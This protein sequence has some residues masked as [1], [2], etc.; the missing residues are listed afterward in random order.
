MSGALTIAIDGPS[1]S[2]KSSTSRQVAR[3]LRMGY[4]DTGAMYRAIACE[5]LERGLAADDADGIIRLTHE[6]DLRVAT[7]PDT[8][9]VTVNGRDV[10]RAIREPEISACV[11]VVAAIPEVR[12]HLTRLMREKIAAHHRRIVVEGRDITTVVAPDAEVRVLLVA[13]PEARVARRA[14][15]L[16]GKADQT[17]VTDQV[18]RRDKDDSRVSNFSQASDAGVVVI[19]STFLSLEEVTDKIVALARQVHENPGDES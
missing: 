2:G 7:D 11:S 1:G 15:E 18:I 17:A 13:D 19:D 8:P 4:L 16:G 3:H 10:T 12:S 6:A 14:A 5:F 9:L